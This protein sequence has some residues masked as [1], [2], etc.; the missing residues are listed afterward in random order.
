MHM[1]SPEMR[2]GKITDIRQVNYKD[3]NRTQYCQHNPSLFRAFAGKEGKT[4]LKRTA[5]V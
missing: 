4:P 2:Y 5:P 1:L 3:L